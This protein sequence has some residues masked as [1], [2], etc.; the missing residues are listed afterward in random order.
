MSQYSLT[1]VYK[2]DENILYSRNKQINRANEKHSRYLKLSNIH[3]RKML[4]LY[5][6]HSKNKQINE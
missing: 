1:A 6:T 3:R 4:E 5:S 2:I